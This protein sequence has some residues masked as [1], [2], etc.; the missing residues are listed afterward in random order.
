MINKLKPTDYK[1]SG[2]Y[3]IRNKIDKRVYIG[4]A[5]DL[6]R[7]YRKH[8]GRF[9]RGTNNRKLQKFVREYGSDNLTFKLL[10]LVPETNNLVKRE[11]FYLDKYKAATKGF[12]SYKVADS[13]LGSEMPQSH[14]DKTSARMMGNSIRSGV[15][16]SKETREAISA[17]KKAWWAKQK[18]M[19]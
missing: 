11:Q 2:I 5:V 4:S 18:A 8:M 10:E 1:K 14:K 3:I 6:M 17:G 13:T 16:L 15:T 19:A 12:N 7:R 9:E